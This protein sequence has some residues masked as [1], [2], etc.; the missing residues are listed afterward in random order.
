MNRLQDVSLL[1]SNLFLH[2]FLKSKF[3]KKNSLTPNK[4]HFRRPIFNNH[5]IFKITNNRIDVFFELYLLHSKS[6][7]VTLCLTAKHALLPKMFEKDNKKVSSGS[8][9]KLVLKSNGST[10][11]TNLN[12]L[13]EKLNSTGSSFIRCIKP[14]QEMK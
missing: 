10:F 5:H 14:N 8:S 4:F 11:R 12:I 9:R 3:T 2:P 13:M 7:E 1:S 6:Y